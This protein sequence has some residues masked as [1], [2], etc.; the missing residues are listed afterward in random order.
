MCINTVL[1]V[2]LKDMWPQEQN[3]SSSLCTSM[4]RI[5]IRTFVYIQE[6]MHLNKKLMCFCGQEKDEISSKK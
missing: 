5:F 2:D 1:F 3:S 4:L 6:I